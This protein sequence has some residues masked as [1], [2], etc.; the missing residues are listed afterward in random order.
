MNPT[1]FIFFAHPTP[2]PGSGWAA[3]AILCIFFA[4]LTYT[5]GVCQSGKNGPVRDAGDDE[6]SDTPR[7]VLIALLILLLAIALVSVIMSVVT[8]ANSMD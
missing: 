7:K 8:K 1:N 4:I 6:P 5:L 3:T 2:G